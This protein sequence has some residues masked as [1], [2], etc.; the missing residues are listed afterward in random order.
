MFYDNHLTNTKHLSRYL[1]EITND[2]MIL[3]YTPMGEDPLFKGQKI[4]IIGHP[5]EMVKDLAASYG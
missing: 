2:S 1:D 4:M 5:N 3:S